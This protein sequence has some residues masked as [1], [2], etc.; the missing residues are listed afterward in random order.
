MHFNMDEQTHNLIWWSTNGNKNPHTVT[1]DKINIC[2]SIMHVAKIT[3]Y[4][5]CLRGGERRCWFFTYFKSRIYKRIFP[6]P[7]NVTIKSVLKFKL[8]TFWHPPKA[9]FSIQFV[10]A[11]IFMLKKI[12]DFFSIPKIW[13]ENA[14]M[15]VLSWI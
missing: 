13:G 11:L 9:N 14:K 12:Y 10:G 6:I 8:S 15:G 2:T 5:M 3:K 1:T 7:N 4:E